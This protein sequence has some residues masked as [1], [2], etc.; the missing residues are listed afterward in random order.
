MMLLRSV[1]MKPVETSKTAFPFQVPFVRHLKRIDFTSPVT[2]LAGENGSGKSTFLEAMA[3][4]ADSITVG[5]ESVKTDKTL[6]AVRAFAYAHL[7]L[8][9]SKRIRKGFFLRSEDFFGYAKRMAQIRADLQ[10]ELEQVD[11]DYKG[12]SAAA[13]GLASMPYHREIEAIQKSYGDGLDSNSHGEGFFKLF[14]ERF[15]GEGLYLLDEPEAALSPTRQLA[16][17]SLINLMTERGGQ[18]IIA[19]H[20]PILMAFPGA[21]ILSFDGGIQETAYDDLEHV[22]VM[23]SFLNNPDSYLRHLMTNDEET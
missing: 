17:L 8:S 16:L 4:A 1:E 18:F 14:R 11:Q 5:A 2:F 9:W 19:T 12:R 21:K 15:V 23:R 20:S 22:T 13:K 7:K 10:A 6:A 3:C